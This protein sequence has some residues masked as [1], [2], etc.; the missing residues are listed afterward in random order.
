MFNVLHEK[1]TREQF[2]CYIGVYIYTYTQSTVQW[3]GIRTLMKL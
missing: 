1:H 2:Y 3:V